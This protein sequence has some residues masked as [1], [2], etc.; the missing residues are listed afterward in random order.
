MP[1]F[2]DPLPDA[3]IQTISNWIAQG[4]LNN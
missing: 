4:A 3:Q 2:A 1:L